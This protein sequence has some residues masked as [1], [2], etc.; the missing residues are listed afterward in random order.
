[1][2]RCRF[3][4]QLNTPSA[5]LK[6]VAK[7][8]KD[9]YSCAQAC[10][11][12][13]DVAN[14]E[15]FTHDGKRARDDAE[16]LAVAAPAA[17][18]DLPADMGLQTADEVKTLPWKRDVKE[19]WRPIFDFIRALSLEARRAAVD[20]AERVKADMLGPA[21]KAKVADKEGHDQRTRELMRQA[22]PFEGG[23][24]R[25][26]PDLY[27]FACL[28][29]SWLSITDFN[30]ERAGDR[31]LTIKQTSIRKFGRDEAVPAPATI[32]VEDALGH[33]ILRIAF[34]VGIEWLNDLILELAAE[35]ASDVAH[36]VNRT[37][38]PPVV[39]CWPIKY[40]HLILR[41]HVTWMRS[42]PVDEPPPFLNK[43]ISTDPNL[44]IIGNK[45]VGY[46]LYPIC[47]Q[48]GIL[49]IAR[50][51]EPDQRDI[52]ASLQAL[53]TYIRHR[54]HEDYFK[55]EIR[56]SA[57]KKDYDWAL[58]QPGVVKAGFPASQA[59]AKPAAATGA[60]ATAGAGAGGS[61]GTG[62]S[63]P[64]SAGAGGAGAGGG[65][66]RA[67][68][69][70]G[71]PG[72]GSGRAGNPRSQAQP[73]PLVQTP[74]TPVPPHFQPASQP[75]AGYN[76]HQPQMQAPQHQPQQQPHFP[77]QPANPYVFTAPQ[78]P[79]HAQ[80]QPQRPRFTKCMA[81]GCLSVPPG[82][83]AT[84][85]FCRIHYGT[86]EY[87]NVTGQVRPKQAQPSGPPPPGAQWS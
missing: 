6:R 56:P 10:G 73:T 33:A 31:Q 3:S 60:A 34:Q 39:T 43:I 53:R 36:H 21:M 75:A 25:S 32:K 12:I 45:V 51:A 23:P 64:G 67:G 15:I 18:V 17:A 59:P 48:A 58:A 40:W 62:A 55:P 54:A 80:Q 81:T 4:L 38:V 8:S 27:H 69:P 30:A 77:Q 7:S 35:C 26:Q 78:A 11:L 84:G 76:P 16:C 28:V 63:H 57:N 61:G 87:N 86:W 22:A 13:C 70:R 44:P 46:C 5:A 72:G 19:G 49:S 2:P 79:P 52:R 65:G 74:H 68:S 42:Q 24:L 66:T 1:M 83:A 71:A 85:P 14:R 29:Q 41:A 82:G 9:L 37:K 50:N 20:A 47:V